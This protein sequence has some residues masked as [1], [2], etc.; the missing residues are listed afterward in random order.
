M[1]EAPGVWNSRSYQS[2]E[3]RLNLGRLR[4]FK[5]YADG[6]RQPGSLLRLVASD[7]TFKSDS[8]NA[9]AEAWAF[10]FYLSETYPREYCKYLALT[11]DREVFSDYSDTERVSDFESVF[12]NEWK[13]LDVKFL[14]FMEDLGK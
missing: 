5:N 3:D 14:R 11:A 12:G 4:E 13:M 10:S 6:G 9:Y 8:S 2:Q 7:R 1:F